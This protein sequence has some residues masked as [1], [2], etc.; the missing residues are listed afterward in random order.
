MTNFK[1]KNTKCK[2]KLEEELE[3]SNSWHEHDEIDSFHNFTYVLYLEKIN[4][5]GRS[6]MFK[7]D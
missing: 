3:V 7:C 2:K 1:F 6:N 4:K 5:Y